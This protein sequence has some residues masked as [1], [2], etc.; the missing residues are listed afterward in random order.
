MQMETINKAIVAVA[1]IL[2]GMC[3]YTQMNERRLR[4]EN[5]ELLNVISEFKNSVVQEQKSVQEDEPDGNNTK[6]DV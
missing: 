2:L 6:D 4:K 5:A 1:V 3:I